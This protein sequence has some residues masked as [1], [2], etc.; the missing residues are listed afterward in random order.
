M[1]SVRK[2]FVFFKVPETLLFWSGD[3]GA[4][5]GFFGLGRRL[6]GGVGVKLLAQVVEHLVGCEEP[7]RELLAVDDG[8]LVLR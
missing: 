5:L 1:E 6:A 3:L 2:E 7:E 8:A 4:A